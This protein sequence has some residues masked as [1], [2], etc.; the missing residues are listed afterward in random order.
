MGSAILQGLLRQQ[1][2]QT[3]PKL[4]YTAHVNSTS[5]LDR[6][7]QDFSAHSDIIQFTSGNDH[8]VSAS[9]ADIILLGFVPGDLH[10]VLATNSIASHLKGKIIISMLAGV[11][12]TQLLETL[13]TNSSGS[14]EDDFSVVRIIPTLSAKIGESVTLLAESAGTSVAAISAVEAIFSRIGTIHRMPERLMDTATAIGAAVHALAIVA[15]D[16]ATD[17]SVADGTYIHYNPQHNCPTSVTLY[18]NST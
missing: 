6:L 2:A 8:L 11:S 14:S 16:T 9:S 10:A 17:A 12:T 5:S 13:Q 4:Q 1:S 7:K 3:A 15:V 18:T